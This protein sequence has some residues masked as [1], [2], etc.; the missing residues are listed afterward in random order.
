MYRTTVVLWNGRD[1]LLFHSYTLCQI[2]WL[3]Y[4]A[5]SADSYVISEELE[6]DY[7]QNR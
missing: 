5:T 6:G 2:S 3:V 4:I 7:F 1:A